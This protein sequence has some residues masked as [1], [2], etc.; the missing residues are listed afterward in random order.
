M[1]ITAS[2]ILQGAFQVY[3]HT[4]S[5]YDVCQVMSLPS[6]KLELSYRFLFKG[7]DSH[8]HHYVVRCVSTKLP[9]IAEGQVSYY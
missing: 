7:E 5:R 6:I 9:I 2:L 8:T 4:A 1:Y 3:V